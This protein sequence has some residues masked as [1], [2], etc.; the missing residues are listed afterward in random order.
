MIPTMMS[1]RIIAAL[2]SATKMRLFLAAVGSASQIRF[3]SAIHDKIRIII[4]QITSATAK[5]S[6]IWIFCPPPINP[7]TCSSSSCS[8]FPAL[9]PSTEQI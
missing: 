8:G 3:P 1:P 7:A 2:M 9:I 5:I 6:Q 4:L